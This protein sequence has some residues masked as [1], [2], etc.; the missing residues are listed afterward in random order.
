[1]IFIIGAIASMLLLGAGLFFPDNPL[2]IRRWDKMYAAAYFS[3]SNDGRAAKNSDNLAAE[4]IGL[5]GAG[6]CGMSGL[7]R[8][9]F[10][11]ST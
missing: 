4:I 8:P 1:M 3:G 5:I 9:V 10:Q 7:G 11:F 2:A 6:C